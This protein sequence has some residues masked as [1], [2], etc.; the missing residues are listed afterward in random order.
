[1]SPRFNRSILSCGA[2]SHSSLNPFQPVS[3]A[4]PSLQPPP[5]PIRSPF[6]EPLE[7]ASR[8][9]RR[10]RPATA[11]ASGRRRPPTKEPR[12]TSPHPPFLSGANRFEVAVHHPRSPAPGSY[13]IDAV[14]DTHPRA[15]R[16]A[17]S[18]SLRARAPRFPSPKRRGLEE[19]D[20]DATPGPGAY[21]NP[22]PPRSAAAPSAA[23]AP[24]ASGRF[25]LSG[26][27]SGSDFPG[28]GAYS[29]DGRT[30]TDP[31]RASDA[32]PSSP[33]PS[34]WGSAPFR[35][36]TDRS[37]RVDPLAALRQAEAEL[38]AEARWLAA[39]GDA[40]AASMVKEE[41]EALRRARVTRQQ[42]EGAGDGE[43]GEERRVVRE[44]SPAGA[45]KSFNANPRSK[46]M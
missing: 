9:S 42:H 18:A 41:A 39:T 16:Q 17:A 1:M 5:T 4:Q 3:R 12:T 45:R 23:F 32:F 20:R 30:T 46:W 31:Y 35:S 36:T 29:V 33:G 26:L 34:A 8:G 24:G 19:E 38:Q 37:G 22:L 2:N 7:R 40:S 25:A 21:L 13:N 43:R 44:E 27:H 28:P 14:P 15:G 6:P 10:S 11:T